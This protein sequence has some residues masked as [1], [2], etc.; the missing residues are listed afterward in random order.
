MTAVAVNCDL[1]WMFGPARDQ[2]IR[3]TCMAFAASD[4]HAGVR[5]GWEALSTE[6]AYYSAVKRDGGGPEDGATLAGMLESIQEDGQPPEIKWP[7]LSAVPADVSLWT[8]P[9]TCAPLYRRASATRH[10]RFAEVLQ[11]LDKGVPVIMTMN[12]SNAFYRPDEDGLVTSAEPSD[13]N[14][15][16]AVIAVGHGWNSAGRLVLV[17]NSWGPDWGI[18]GH[19]WLGEGY[20]A[21]RLYGLAE[22]RE[23]RTNVSSH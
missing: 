8:P 10:A 14:R 11:L 15:R 2:G 12:L 3:P 7:Y 1:R 16:H 4:T 13:P 20:L 9:P 21:P 19:A 22:M 5:P 6:F 18:D 23:D 17:R